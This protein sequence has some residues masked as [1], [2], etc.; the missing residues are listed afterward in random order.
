MAK[1]II[2]G[3]W[4]QNG[5]LKSSISLTK[6]ITSAV[7][8]NQYSADIII[9]PPSVYLSEVNELLGK[10]R[11]Q[12]GSQNVS[13]FNNGAYTGEISS[14]MLKDLKIKY[15]LVGHS[16]RRHVLNE[17]EITLSNKVSRLYE[18]NIKI[19][20]CIGETLNQYKNKKTKIILKNQI[21]YLFKAN[22]NR[23]QNSP[24]NLIIAYEPVW[25]IGS[26]LVPTQ[27]ELTLIFDYIRETINQFNKKYSS[28]K[29][30]YGG[31]VTP[32]N[33]STLMTTQ[34]MDG[35]LIGGASLMPKKFIDICSTI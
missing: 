16:E 23:I 19:I 17:D 12:I 20:Y 18:K 24:N 30:L 10:K 9:F 8:K 4:K 26:G 14:S 32:D 35:L 28:I 6:S 1:K 15:C 33:A 34:Y 3:N 2:A 11:V 7:Q 31:S 22:G 29:I 5:T 27:E 13:E 25:A 21:K